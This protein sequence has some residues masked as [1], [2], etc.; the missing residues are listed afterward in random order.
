MKRIIE[1]EVVY[2]HEIEVDTDDLKTAEQQIK[3]LY[4]QGIIPRDEPITHSCRIVS[5]TKSVPSTDQSKPIKAQALYPSSQK[6]YYGKAIVTKQSDGSQILWSYGT[7]IIRRDATG[8]LHRLWDAW[9][10]TTGKHIRDFCG[11][12]KKAFMELELEENNA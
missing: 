1:Y 8:A 3:D 2:T 7:A 12:N 9:S 4:E 10:A 5:Q 11:L 6:S